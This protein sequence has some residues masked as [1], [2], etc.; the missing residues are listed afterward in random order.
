M[1]DRTE[2]KAEHSE[3]GSVGTLV[4]T[5]EDCYTGTVSYDIPGAG[6]AG[7]VPIQRIVLDNVPLCQA[8]G[9]SE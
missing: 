1:F 3:P 4:V 6:L 2:P 9:Y 5:F 7:E 8:L